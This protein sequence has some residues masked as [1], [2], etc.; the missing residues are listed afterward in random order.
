MASQSK[1]GQPMGGYRTALWILAAGLVLA[2]GAVQAETKRV[3]LGVLAYRGEDEAFARWS[4]LATYLSEQIPDHAFVVHPLDLDAMARALAHDRL[5]FVLTNPGHYVELEA[6]HGI[7]RIATLCSLYHGIPQ[8]T[9]GAVI[10]TRADRPDIQD[11]SGLRGKSFMAVDRDA[12]GGFQFAW[13]ELKAQGV[14]P[15]H[16]L[17]R[18]EYSG[19]PQDKIVYAVRDGRV[20]AGTVRTETLEQMAAEG[21]IVLGDFR[22]LNAQTT[23]GFPFAHSTRLYPEWP[24]ARGRAVDDALAQRVSIALLTMPADHPAGR[25]GGYAGW[26][27]PLD[28]N[29]VHELFRELGVGPY[30]PLPTT[31][32]QLVRTHWVAFAS[33][34]LALLLML[35]VTVYVLQLNGQLQAEVRERRRAEAQMRK[36]SSAVEQAA[37]AV[38]ITDR[39][40]SIEYVN[41]AFERVSGFRRDEVLGYTP[42]LVR[43]GLHDQR[44][45]EELWGT[46]LDGRP[47][48]GLFINRRKDGLLFYEEKAITPLRDAHGRVTHFV[49]TGRDVTERRRAEEQA[50]RHREE[51]ARVAR[52]S[53]LGEMTSSIAHELN[54][55]LTAIA[56]YAAGCMRRLRDGRLEREPLLGAMQRVAGQAQRAGDIIRHV[57][58]LVTH[59][60]P[61]RAVADLNA[62]V[63]EAAALME[64]EIRTHGVSMWFHLTKNLPA[65][66]VDAIQVEQVVLN[67]LRNATEAMAENGDRR[68]LVV[69]TAT[70]HSGDVE[71]LVRDSG[72]GLPPQAERLFEAFFTTKAGGMGLGLAISRTIVEAH[73]GRLWAEPNGGRGAAFR[74]TLPYACSGHAH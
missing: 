60:E 22:V 63:K 61:Q 21:K 56:N 43:S 37:D 25:A 55:P 35:V 20:D 26:T 23:R 74:F 9:F 58:R 48:H 10:F 44:F 30:R 54:Q 28:Y 69:R 67:L 5:D 41:P 13:R 45:Y 53:V 39:D 32:W 34:T 51:L 14:D 47:F 31:F 15:F 18:L 11:L 19:F 62:L 16:D 57:R 71:V 7:T 3:E 50:R 42:R 4:P 49:S 12:F 17:T 68:L 72:P 64:A 27:V 8:T 36:L 24:F 29:A 2:A 33:G 73:G 59:R 46:L 40:G 1:R 66:E 38:I 65:V 52:V 6:A 70:T